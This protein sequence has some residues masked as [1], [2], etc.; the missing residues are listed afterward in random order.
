MTTIA[1]HHHVFDGVPTFFR[2]SCSEAA[3]GRVW[4][5][6][7][8]IRYGYRE[9]GNNLAR[10]TGGLLPYSADLDEWGEQVQELLNA[11]SANDREAVWRWYARIFPK[12]MAL[13][14]AKRRAAFVDGVFEASEE[15]EIAV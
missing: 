9:V 4:S 13:V 6:Q 11:L 14:P 1:K 10:S 5:S 15:D 12:C 8:W 2:A 3:L 7:G